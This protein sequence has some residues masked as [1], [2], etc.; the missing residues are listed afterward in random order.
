MYA[1]QVQKDIASLKGAP[2]TLEPRDTGD[3]SCRGAGIAPLGL[4]IYVHPLLMLHDGLAQHARF[5]E[6]FSGFGSHSPRV[7]VFFYNRAF[8][9]AKSS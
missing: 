7:V 1:E 2:R 8:V 5:K 9:M 4:T 6:L 3:D